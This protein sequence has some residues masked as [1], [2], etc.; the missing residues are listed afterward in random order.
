M[1]N[2]LLLVALA[3]LLIGGGL[4]YGG[5]YVNNFIKDQLSVQK[6]TFGTADE[7]TKGGRA[8]LVQYAGVTVTTGPEAKA[9]ASY[10][11]GHLEKVANGQTYSEVSNAYL[12]DTT[13]QKLA[14]QRQTLFM[15][16]MLRGTLLNVWGWSI[17]GMIA[18]YSAMGLWLAA[19]AI[20]VLY[21]IVD[22]KSSTKK[23]VP[24]K[25]GKKS[26]K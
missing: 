13:N 17:V 16:E 9:F 12:K 19:V 21:L 24:K 20:L 8:D 26:R 22:K 15:G 3:L 5:N 23:Q 1:K 4:L 25:A 7:L 2:L 18:I 11:Q 6:I 14:G 10:I